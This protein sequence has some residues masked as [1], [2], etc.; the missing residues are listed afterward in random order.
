MATQSAA[1]TAAASSPTTP[2]GRRA[3]AVNSD[4]PSVV[5]KARENSAR[6]RLY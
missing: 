2:A 3:R 1:A 5:A 6:Q 4:A